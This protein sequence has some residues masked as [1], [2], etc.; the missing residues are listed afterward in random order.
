MLLLAVILLLINITKTMTSD[1]DNINE[2]LKECDIDFITEFIEFDSNGAIIGLGQY[3]YRYEEKHKLLRNDY[4]YTI[5]IDEVYT[6]IENYEDYSIPYKKFPYDFTG[7]DSSIYDSSRIT[8]REGNLR[9]NCIT[10]ELS[11]SKYKD[12]FESILETFWQ[13][14]D[15]TNNYYTEAY[16]IYKLRYLEDL[17]C[18]AVAIERPKIKF[19]IFEE[20]GYEYEDTTVVLTIK[21]FTGRIYKNI[22]YYGELGLESIKILFPDCPKITELLIEYTNMNSRTVANTIISDEY[23][24]GCDWNDYRTTFD[25][26]FIM[27]YIRYVCEETDISYNGF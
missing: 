11:N 6:F 26:D 1:L 10:R 12:K 5:P 7:K 17:L 20:D 22:Y 13:I 2:I 3:W 24:I 21:A 18:E 14:I 8:G 16:Y 15:D 25:K 19:L 23:K 4:K 27:E 9:L